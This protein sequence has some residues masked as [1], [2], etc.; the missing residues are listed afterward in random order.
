MALL[1]VENL[2]TVHG[3]GGGWLS[4]TPKIE[5]KAVDD[6]SFSLD[7]GKTVGIAGETGCGKTSLA[8]TILRIIPPTSG[9]IYFTERPIF[10]M[11]HGRFRALRGDLQMIFSHPNA[12]FRPGWTVRRLFHEVL[13]LHQRE[14]GRQESRDRIDY[15]LKAVGLSS[16]C[17]RLYPGELNL[18]DR[19]RVCIARIL[20]A[21][22]RLLI[23]DDPTR[24]LDTVSQAR[25]LDILKDIQVHWRITL[26]FLARDYAAVEHMSDQIHVMNRG[27]FVES[28]TPD[29]L[30]HSARHE[31][32]RQLLALGG[33]P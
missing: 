13:R 7:E 23:C 24:Y 32:T 3:S 21:Q 10:K 1:R 26:L 22:P 29:E 2:T 12:S 18:F 31:Y 6:V 15:L 5:I 19:Q 14:L 33:A 20:A 30:F 9:A 28:G 8:L 11:S 16:D 17:L 27:R 4:G 25:I